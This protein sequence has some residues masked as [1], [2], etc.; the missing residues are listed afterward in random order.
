MSLQEIG[1][2]SWAKTL[3]THEKRLFFVGRPTKKSDEKKSHEKVRHFSSAPSKN[4]LFRGLAVGPTKKGFFHRPW[5]GPMKKVYCGPNGR[6]KTF[7]RGPFWGR[8]KTVPAA[9]FFRRPLFPSAGPRNSLGSPPPPKQVPFFC[10]HLTEITIYSIHIYTTEI[11]HQ[12]ALTIYIKPQPSFIHLKFIKSIIIPTIPH[13]Q[14]HHNSSNP[15]QTY[16]VQSNIVQTYM[17][18][19]HNQMCPLLN[20]FDTLTIVDC[21]SCGR[22]QIFRLH[23]AD[24]RWGPPLHQESHCRDVSLI[25]ANEQNKCGHKCIN[26][27]ML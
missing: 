22:F 5:V 14:V 19:K 6:R 1:F 13:T 15:P 25:P 12:K 4:Y 21:W 9:K 27:A 17:T 23:C 11:T 18:N 16:I 24:T 2:F 8:R 7:F 10:F 20:S 26:S 3:K